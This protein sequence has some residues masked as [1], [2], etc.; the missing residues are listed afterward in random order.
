MPEA[1]SLPKLSAEFR[2]VIAAIGF[3]EYGRQCLR[4]ALRLAARRDRP[5]IAL[6]ILHETPRNL[7]FYR[8]QDDGEVLRPN[9]D[10]ASDL[11]AAFSAEVIADEPDTSNVSL[12]QLVVPGLPAGRIVEVARLTNAEL[13]VIGARPKTALDRLLS[14]DVTWAVLRHAGCPVL[15]VDA[16]GKPVDPHDLR[17]GRPRQPLPPAAGAT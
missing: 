7:G 10:V 4:Q 14:R 13:I 11:L 3:D 1:A 5:A 12:R 8:R 6:H 15:V 2:P 16:L 17:P 9:A